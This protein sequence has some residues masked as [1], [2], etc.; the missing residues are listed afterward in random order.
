[1]ETSPFLRDS[2][3]AKYRAAPQRRVRQSIAYVSGSHVR[4]FDGGRDQS[5][6]KT[7]SERAFDRCVKCQYIYVRMCVHPEAAAS[8]LI[9]LNFQ[10]ILR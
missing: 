4:I 8:T 2:P 1:M 9:A 10:S 6:N 7:A 5:G 3:H